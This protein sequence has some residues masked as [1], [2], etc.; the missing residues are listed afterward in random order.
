[1]AFTDGSLLNDVD[2]LVAAGSLTAAATVG[3]APRVLRRGRT[4]DASVDTEILA[5]DP[6]RQ[7]IGQEPSGPSPIA[8]A[9]DTPDAMEDAPLA[10]GWVLRGDP[11]PKMLVTSTSKDGRMSS[12]VWRCEPSQFNFS[13][14]SDEYVHII[15]GRV[16][17]LADGIVH[18]L[19]PGSTA[20]FPKGLTA[21]WTVHE[22]IH[23]V[24]VLSNGSRWAQRAKRLRSLLLPR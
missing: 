17:V 6:A 24:F 13:Y 9:S 19:G 12:G 22:P 1:M 16:T 23:K 4:G 8:F 10:E 7:F 18:R 20:M 3:L 14:V 21:Q 5:D 11:K 2:A 15:S